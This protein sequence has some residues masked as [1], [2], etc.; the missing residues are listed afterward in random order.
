MKRAHLLILAAWLIHAAAWFL[1][2]IDDG[3]RFPSGLPGW[4]A[5]RT[6][7]SPVW[8]YADT[9]Y[10][11]IAAVAAALSAVT[12]IFFVLVSPWVLLR[13][14]H[15]ARRVSAWIAAAS[16][17]LDGHWYFFYGRSESG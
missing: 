15:S 6:A 4:Q 5:F 3:V 11:G 16:F 10:S 9:H 12:T 17:V 14:S 1:P 13:G 2:V 8:P 7:F